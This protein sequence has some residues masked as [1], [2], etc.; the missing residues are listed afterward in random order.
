MKTCEDKQNRKAGV[1][2][3]KWWRP[4]LLLAVVIVPAA[5]VSHAQS[6]SEPSVTQQIAELIQAMARTQAQLEQS[7]RQLEEMRSQLAELEIRVAQAERGTAAQTRPPIAASAAEPQSNSQTETDP[8]EA[9]RE[10]QQIDEAQIATHEQSKVESESKYPVKITGL[11][12]FNGF[13]NTGAVDMAPAPTVAVPGSGSTGES[14]RQTVLG[15]DARGPHLFGARSYADLRVDFY[16]SPATGSP[17]SEYSGVF[18]TNTALLRLRTAHAGLQ[19]ESTEAYFALDRPIITPDTPTSLTAVAEPPLAWSGN[20]WTW[21]P[22]LGVTRRFNGGGRLGVE[23][24]AALIDVGDAP[25]TPQ[26][27]SSAPP[28]SSAEQSRW[29]GIVAR[30]ALLGNERDQERSHFGLG[31]FF[32]PHNSSLEQSFDSWAAT[33]DARFFLP[34]HLEFSGSGYRG[35]ALGGLGGGAYKD[36]AYSVNEITGESYLVPLDD[37]GGWVQLKER[38]TERLESNAAFGMDNAFAGELLRFASTGGSMYQNL[39]RNRTFT[40]NFIYSP[41]AFLLFSIEYRRLDSFPVLA[42][43]ARSNVIGLG[44]GYKF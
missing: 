7:Q 40:G 6:S 31:G 33:A 12:L 35:A 18:N 30:V 32:A 23:S 13:V 28:P 9:M 42:A 26:F 20:L 34:A 24:E 38:F 37:A 11:L 36:I 43:P 8:L 22:Q 27:E 17:A 21:N 19:W 2:Q 14:I 16:G 5:Q 15:F 10:R 41:S 25:L 4:A 29:P 3:A 1:W 44:A 39:A